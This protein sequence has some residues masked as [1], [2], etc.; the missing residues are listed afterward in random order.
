M[1]FNVSLGPAGE[2]YADVSCDNG[3]MPFLYPLLRCGMTKTIRGENFVAPPISVTLSFVW[4]M[5]QSALRTRRAINSM[6]VT[7]VCDGN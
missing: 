7:T 6:F 5:V 2:D 3:A 4:P 1:L